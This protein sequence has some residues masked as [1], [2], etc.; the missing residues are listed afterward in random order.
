M[1]R[2]RV[3]LVYCVAHHS[4]RFADP[5]LSVEDR[6]RF[7]LERTK[8]NQSRRMN[9]AQRACTEPCTSSSHLPSSSNFA[10]FVGHRT[11]DDTVHAKYSQ[12]WPCKRAFLLI[13]MSYRV[14]F[15]SASPQSSLLLFFRVPFFSA[16]TH[17]RS[18]LRF[19]VFSLV[20]FFSRFSQRA[21][22][23]IVPGHQSRIPSTPTL[24][25]T[26]T[27][28]QVCQPYGILYVTRLS[29][30]R[31]SPS[32]LPTFFSVSRPLLLSAF[33]TFSLR[34]CTRCCSAGVGKRAFVLAICTHTH[35]VRCTL[36][37]AAV[38]CTVL[39]SRKKSAKKRSR[40]I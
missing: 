6:K 31:R 5:S 15:C 16:R 32:L 18:E 13:F 29:A 28:T 11:E 34:S 7:W 36:F 35:N 19:F 37:A 24:A 30:W 3:S 26:H 9:R 10:N 33:E 25:H 17:L 27:L 4:I 40:R 8:T 21:K 1:N 38:A 23:R 12:P 20:H 22:R 14:F 39:L 2:S